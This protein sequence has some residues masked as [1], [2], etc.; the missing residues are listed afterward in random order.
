V[1]VEGVK[2]ASLAFMLMLENARPVVE[3][4]LSVKLAIRALSVDPRDGTLITKTNV[5]VKMDIILMSQG[6]FVHPVLH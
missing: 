5:N 6:K 2:N 3:C 1:T 4:V